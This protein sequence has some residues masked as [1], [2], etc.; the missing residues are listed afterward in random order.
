V[1][2]LAFTIDRPH[3]EASKKRKV[4]WSAKLH[5]FI[6]CLSCIVYA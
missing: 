3:L 6:C 2:D 1:S 5:A 4:S